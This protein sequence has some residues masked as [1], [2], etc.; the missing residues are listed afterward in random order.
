MRSSERVRP[1]V[2]IGVGT[3]PDALE[4]GMEG[5][6][7]SFP[8]RRRPA[9]SHVS[10]GRTRCSAGVAKSILELAAAIRRCRGSA[11]RAPTA[12]CNPARSL[13]PQCTVG[14]AEGS[15]ARAGFPKGRSFI[16]ISPVW[17]L[18]PDPTPLRPGWQ[19]SCPGPALNRFSSFDYDL[20]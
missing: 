16:G 8:S 4:V 3:W 5:I 18:A 14:W 17:W 12:D 1:P 7:S 13:S 20:Q 10:D 15:T 2:G 19:G 6:P 11:G 9:S